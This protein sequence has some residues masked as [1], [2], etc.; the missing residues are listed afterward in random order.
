MRFATRALAAGAIFL[1]LV[2]GA[3]ATVVYDNTGINS[4]TPDP[5]T[6]S[7]APIYASFTTGAAALD[8][9]HVELVLN[10]G[11]V[12]S[13]TLVVT[14]YTDSSG[15]GNVTALSPLNPTPTGPNLKTGVVVGTAPDSAISASTA[16]I[17]DF[18]VASGTMSLAANT[19]YWV[20]VTD[21]GGSASWDYSTGGGATTPVGS[22]P[23]TVSDVTDTPSAEYSDT[24]TYGVLNNSINPYMM[25][26]SGNA[27]SDTT[28]CTA[29]TAADT[30]ST[31]EP[32]SLA[33]LG[34]AILGLGAARR[35]RRS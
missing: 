6:G 12:S 28:A 5:L 18:Q 20:G 34:V 16:T 14:V 21:T 15:T 1:G 13:S 7:D 29:T 27:S 17:Y 23:Y 26:V 35:Y 10:G 2:G 19:T 24:T 3:R 11:T 31:P 30:F 9:A 25:C 33:I 4:S 32:A 8:L 22:A